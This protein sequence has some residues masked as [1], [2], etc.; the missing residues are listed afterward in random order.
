MAAGR[1]PTLE[2]FDRDNRQS[3]LMQGGMSET[4]SWIQAVRMYPLDQ[5]PDEREAGMKLRGLT[6]E[7]MKR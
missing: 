4:E 3:H 1:T 6:E 7:D 2:D 5:H